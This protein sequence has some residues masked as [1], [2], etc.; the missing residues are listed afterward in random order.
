V[1]TYQNLK[2]SHFL[3]VGCGKNSG[4]LIPKDYPLEESKDDNLQALHESGFVANPTQ[5]APIKEIILQQ[6]SSARVA[7]GEASKEKRAGTSA[8]LQN[9]TSRRPSAKE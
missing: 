3:F 6:Y 4:A 8:L 9:A 1:Q 5:E 2:Q 7:R